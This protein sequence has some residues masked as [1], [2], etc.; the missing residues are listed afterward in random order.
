MLRFRPYKCTDAEKIVLW[1]N[2]SLSFYKWSAGR[3]GEFPL[4]PERLNEHY[5]EESKNG[6]TMPF[7]AYDEN[8]IAGH[9]IIRFLDEK[10]TDARLGFIAVDS[11][12]RG[13]NLG[14]EM[15][16][17]AID[18]CRDYLKAKRVSLGVFENNPAAVRCYEKAGFEKVENG[19][20]EV[21]LCGEIWKAFEMEIKL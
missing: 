8:G 1:F 6:T 9:L 7:T 21:E 11:Q 5:A 12:R 13:Q 15:I 16:K 20:Y 19:S 17:M 18:F 14:G 4:T 2:D 10:M 3:F